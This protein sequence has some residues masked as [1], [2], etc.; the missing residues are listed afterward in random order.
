MLD[1]DDEFNEVP[2]QHMIL[3]EHLDVDDEEMR[4]NEYSRECLYLD[5]LHLLDII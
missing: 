1:D 4:I 5:I 2:H 3:V